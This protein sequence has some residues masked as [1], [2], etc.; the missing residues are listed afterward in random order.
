MTTQADPPGE[1]LISCLIGM[2]AVESDLEPGVR[3]TAA[4]V[5]PA[6]NG[7]YYW[8]V[9][10]AFVYG[11]SYAP[12]GSAEIDRIVYQNQRRIIS[13]YTSAVLRAAASAWHDGA[14]LDVGAVAPFRRD[15]PAAALSETAPP[16][17]M[18]NPGADDLRRGGASD[19]LY[20][21]LRDSGDVR[22]RVRAEIVR[23]A[24]GE[25]DAA[26]DYQDPDSLYREPNGAEGE[27]V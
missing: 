9:A 5:R 6:A 2:L 11:T 20:D 21:P 12:P 26:A 23:A 13:A 17:G 1:S 22:A 25:P 19:P 18:G 10:T 3:V 7:Q 24:A 4:E 14:A 8:S 27:G 16:F 15:P